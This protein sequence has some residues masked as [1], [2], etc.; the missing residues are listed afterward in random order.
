MDPVWSPGGTEIAFRTEDDTLATLS[1]D[2]PGTSW[3]SPAPRTSAAPRC[4]ETASAS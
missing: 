1:V 3:K 4:G 2:D